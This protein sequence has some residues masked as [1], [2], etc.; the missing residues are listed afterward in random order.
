[1]TAKVAVIIKRCV[2]E[3]RLL[4][5]RADIVVCRRGQ[6]P[7]DLVIPLLGINLEEVIRAPWLESAAPCR[8]FGAH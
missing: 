1:M 3:F 8:L 7:T 6:L 5:Q 2:F 4:I